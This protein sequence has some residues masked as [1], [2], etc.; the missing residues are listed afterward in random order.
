MKGLRLSEPGILRNSTETKVA[1]EE[2]KGKAVAQD[3]MC[4][5]SCY[6]E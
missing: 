3:T 6:S 1:G 2:E 5:V 4:Q